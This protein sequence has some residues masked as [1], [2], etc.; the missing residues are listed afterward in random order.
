MAVPFVVKRRTSVVTAALAGRARQA[1][2]LNVQ[3][4]LG[5]TKAGD[6]PIYRATKFE[7]V[8]NRNTAK[9]LDF[10]LPQPVLAQ[11]DELIE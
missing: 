9:A 11:I 4:I 2:A 8:I 10:T 3:Q 6:L 7:L 1:Q 5:G